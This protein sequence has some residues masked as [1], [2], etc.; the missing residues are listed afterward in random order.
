MD[1]IVNFL[2][3]YTL[4]SKKY[5]INNFGCL[6]RIPSSIAE[7]AKPIVAY[8]KHGNGT[9]VCR[10][11]A[12]NY[13]VFW[14]LTNLT[15]SVTA[16][17]PSGY[18]LIY[19]TKAGMASQIVPKFM[20]MI[21]IQGANIVSDCYNTYSASY[22]A[23]MSNHTERLVAGV[24]FVNSTISGSKRLLYS[25]ECSFSLEDPAFKVNV[26]SNLTVRYSTTG[27]LTNVSA[28]VT[29]PGECPTGQVVSYIKLLMVH[30][31]DIPR[32]NPS[33]RLCRRNKVKLD[34]LIIFSLG[35]NSRGITK[36]GTRPSS[37]N[38]CL[39]YTQNT[40]W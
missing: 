4:N 5:K 33:G 30:Y 16:A 9:K 8:T 38:A 29:S 10:P 35:S 17:V 21:L 20:T 18:P 39:V 19:V 11:F 37:G 14:K 25:V 12:D 36:Q 31:E 24:T 13:V 3:L 6:G 2:N 22:D 27:I 40:E 28:M 32:M 15:R 26:T 34:Q 23:A 7:M 1:D